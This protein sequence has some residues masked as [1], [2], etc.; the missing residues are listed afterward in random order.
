V[1]D[2]NFRILGSAGGNVA[3][4]IASKFGEATEYE[5][6]ALM[7]AGLVLFLVTLMVN[8]VASFIVNRSSKI[9]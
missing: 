4:L 3:S 9:I 1:F 8:F 7:A 6:K 5:L 2:I